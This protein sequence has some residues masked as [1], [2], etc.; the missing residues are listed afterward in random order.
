LSN[1]SAH[2]NDLTLKTEVMAAEMATFYI[3]QFWSDKCNNIGER[4]LSTT[5]YWPQTFCSGFGGLWS[6]QCLHHPSD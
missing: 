3:K 1:K 2:S 6:S 5:S 4:F